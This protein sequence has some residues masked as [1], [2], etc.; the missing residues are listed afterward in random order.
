MP[1][2]YFQ[3]EKSIVESKTIGQ[4]TKIWA[5]AHILPGAT[6]GRDCNICDHTFIE[7]DVTVG[8]R[9]TIK[10]GVQLWDG[11]TIEDDVFIGP[12]A[13]FTNDPFPRSK[14]YPK[15]FSR[16][17]VKQGASIGANATILPGLTIGER[18]MIGAGTVITRNVPP[19]AI[20]VGNP[21]RIVGY[22]GA[23]WKESVPT[24]VQERV[25]ARA[26]HVAGVTLHRLPFAADMRGKLSFGEIERQVP[27]SVNRF[28][29]VYGVPGK[30][31]RG[32]H[33]HYRCHQFLICTH[34]TCSVMA[35]DGTNREEFLLDDPTIGVYLPPRVW[36]VQYKYSADAVLLVFASEY[37]DAKDYIRSYSDFLAILHEGE[38]H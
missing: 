7:N 26:T 17:V 2:E 5:M 23:Q 37:Y 20:V 19:L 14:Q 34:G 11:T 8:D 28:F 30:E 38:G 25:G 10:C 24:S 4:G 3:H 13:T 32:E 36:G 21:G 9:V 33:A 18:S 31:V 27:F 15:V 12:N 22:D 1:L 6:I 29:L 16:T 35:D